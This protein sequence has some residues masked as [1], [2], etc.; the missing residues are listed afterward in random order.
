MYGYLRSGVTKL[1][2]RHSVTN[3]QIEI[4]A[5]PSLVAIHPLQPSVAELMKAAEEVNTAIKN[6]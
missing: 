5:Q 2:S 3:V 4:F 6:K 1:N